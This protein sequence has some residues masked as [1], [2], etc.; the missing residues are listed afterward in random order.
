MTIPGTPDQLT[1]AAAPWMLTPVE[2]NTFRPPISDTI[3]LWTVTMTTEKHVPPNPEPRLNPSQSSSTEEHNTKRNETNTTDA[4]IQCDSD[5]YDSPSDDDDLHF[6]A[7]LRNPPEMGESNAESAERTKRIEGE[8][9]QM[10]KRRQWR[11][12]HRRAHPL[13]TRITPTD[14]YTLLPATYEEF[15]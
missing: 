15:K 14:Q 11:R 9:E 1:N 8:V 13:K 7:Q 5:E 4:D 2:E 12:Q 3:Q 6:R 10:K